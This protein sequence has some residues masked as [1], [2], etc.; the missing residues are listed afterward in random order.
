MADKS[1]GMIESLKDFM[2]SERTEKGAKAPV[3]RGGK[4]RRDKID[5]AV[6]EA[7]NGRRFDAQH[8]D[9]SQ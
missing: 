5:A 2:F 7:V 6:D 8:T 3:G 9:S 1:K 4:Q